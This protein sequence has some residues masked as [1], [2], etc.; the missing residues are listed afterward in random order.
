M[1]TPVTFGSL[2]FYEAMAAMLNAD[3]VW[4]DK[5]K[6]LSSSMVYRY[7]APLEGDF[8]LRFDKGTVAEV[9]TPTADDVEHADFVISGSSDTWRAAFEGKVNP[10]IALAK[11]QI[12]VKGETKLLIKNMSA[13]KYV[14]E[15]MS[16]IPFA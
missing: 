16:R 7:E 4:L 12:K 8:F 3:P 6:N 15:A 9:K 1:T 11:G 10:T 2:A 5:G 13:F 14:L